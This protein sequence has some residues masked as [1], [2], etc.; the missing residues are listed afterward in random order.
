MKLKFIIL[1][2]FLSFFAKAQ[3]NELVDGT[4][5]NSCFS[6]IKEGTFKGQVGG[7]LKITTVKGETVTVPFNSDPALLSIVPDPDEVYDISFKKYRVESA[8]GKVQL[9]YKTYAFANALELQLNRKTYE[10]GGIDGSCD[11]VI[12]GL[13]YEY[14]NNKQ[15]EYLLLHFTKDVGL[16]VPKSGRAIATFIK[17]GS[18]LMFSISR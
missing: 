12:N 17:K 6:Q 7:I 2:V 3:E 13:E 1:F 16:S 10:L 14:L 5:F 15:S 9:E 18:M 11:A 8:D 4:G